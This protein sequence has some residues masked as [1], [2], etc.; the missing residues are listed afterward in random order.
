MTIDIPL[1][2]FRLLHRHECVGVTGLGDFRTTPR[3]AVVD[4]VQGVIY[5]PNKI[6]TF[7]EN[8]STSGDLLLQSIKQTYNIDGYTFR[9]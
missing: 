5:P 6:L 8:P 3:S 2:L 9:L 4:H 1:I 7:E